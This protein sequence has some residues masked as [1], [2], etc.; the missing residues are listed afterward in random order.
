M[1]P[2]LVAG[3]QADP[4]GNGTVL[5]LGFSQLLLD[6]KPLERTHLQ[7]DSG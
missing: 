6:H 2:D 1:L 4:L 5:L 7:E 3:P